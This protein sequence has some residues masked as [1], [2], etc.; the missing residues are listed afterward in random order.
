MTILVCPD[1][2]GHEYLHEEFCTACADVLDEGGVCNHVVEWRGNA[3]C[4][5]RNDRGA[6]R[7]HPDPSNPDQAGD[8]YANQPD[9]E[10][11]GKRESEAA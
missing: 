10:P 4:V 11:Q 3:E 6:L 9:N 5:C 1:C 8:W 2:N 7:V